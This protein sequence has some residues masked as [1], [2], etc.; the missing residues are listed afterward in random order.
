MMEFSFSFLL[1]HPKYIPDSW[2]R[3]FR[4]YYFKYDR[5]IIQFDPESSIYNPELFYTLR[6]GRFTFGNR[7][8]TNEYQV[9]ELGMRDNAESLDNPEIVILGDSHTMG[10]GIDQHKTFPALIEANIGAKVLNAGMSSYGTVREIKALDKIDLSQTQYIII[11]YCYNDHGENLHYIER[12][13]MLEVSSEETLR[14]KKRSHSETINYYFLKHTLLFFGILGDKLFERLRATQTINED[15][16]DSQE[17]PAATTKALPVD[18]A[19]AFLNV[20]MNAPK[21]EAV[22]QIIITH[23]DRQLNDHFIYKLRQLLKQEP[24]RDLAPK[25]SLIDFSEVLLKTDYFILDDHLNEG[26]HG[27]VAAGLEK[28]IS[29]NLPTEQIKIYT[30]SDFH[31]EHDSSGWDFNESYMGDQCYFSLDANTLWGPGYKMNLTKKMIDS[32]YTTLSVKYDY[33]GLSTNAGMLV[34]DIAEEENHLWIGEPMDKKLYTSE[35]NKWHTTCHVIPLKKRDEI[36]NM[37]DANMHIYFWN[38]KKKSFK[39]NNIEI[40]LRKPDI[41]IYNFDW[42]YR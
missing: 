30:Q 26:G 28:A 42:R 40:T 36:E 29:N 11:Q 23:L 25:I 15:N 39:L 6:P 16:N 38:N 13:N 14:Q 34:I 22:P 1:N 33:H 35:E 9:N 7:E 37:H 19:K 17:L 5:G 2:L 31:Q 8:I 27:K 18:D 24:Y 3:Y 10:W 41:N 12:D 4:H 32:G 21:L 20:L